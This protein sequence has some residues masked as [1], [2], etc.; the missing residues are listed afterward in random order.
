MLVS[1]KVNKYKFEISIINAFSSS[2]YFLVFIKYQN[3]KNIKKLYMYE[4]IYTL[5]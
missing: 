5:I 3:Y 2:Y 4:N 1:S